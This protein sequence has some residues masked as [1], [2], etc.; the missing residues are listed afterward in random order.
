MGYIQVVFEGL[1]SYRII[2]ETDSVIS[3]GANYTLERFENETWKDVLGEN[4][5]CIFIMYHLGPNSSEVY[6]LGV[7]LGEGVYRLGK[8]I[9]L[10]DSKETKYIKCDIFVR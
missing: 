6:P 7:K 1:D 8:Y 3:F 4:Q 9:A 5:S 10:S 2:N